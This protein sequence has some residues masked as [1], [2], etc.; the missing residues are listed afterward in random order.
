M[1]QC[2]HDTTPTAQARRSRKDGR[3]YSKPEEQLD[4]KPLSFF[5]GLACFLLACNTNTSSTRM[6]EPMAMEEQAAAN[7]EWTPLFDGKEKSIR[8]WH[9]YGKETAGNAWEIT[10]DGTLH[11][12]VS[13]KEDR[14]T[15]GGD[16]VTNEQFEDFH[17]KLDWKIAEG[18]N[19]GILFYV[20]ED[21]SRYEHSW[22]SGPEM[23]LLDNERHPDG[24]IHKHRAG[25]LYDLIAAS[26][27]AAKPAGE[28]NEAEI[29]SQDGQ[30]DFY[31]NGLNVLSTMMWN[32]QWSNHIANSKFSEHPGFGTYKKGK[33]ALQDHGDP[34]WF[35]N[36]RIKR[37]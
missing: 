34:V 17:L 21:T 15:V 10:E 12:D 5:A 25:D 4:G 28:W 9:T 32:E 16:L 37:L 11:L 27:E 26:V 19:S 24:Q 23:Q 18:G 8:N 1:G 2:T 30:L 35:R 3:L 13:R 22:Q 36:I 33:I 14:K 7:N 20:Q 31:L 6:E 29:I